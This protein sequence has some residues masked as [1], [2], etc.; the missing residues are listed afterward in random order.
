MQPAVV[1]VTEVVDLG[2]T[3]IVRAARAGDVRAFESIVA[4]RLPGAFRLAVAI[5]GND[6][7]AADATQNAL[8]ATWRE[9]PRRGGRGVRRVVPP[10]PRQRVPHAD[11]AQR[12]LP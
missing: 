2:D 8:V 4:S 12:T 10:D 9:L 5:L 11:P 1:R 6:S 3:R 7:E